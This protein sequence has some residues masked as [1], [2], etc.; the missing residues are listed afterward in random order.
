[1]VPTLPGALIALP[2]SATTSFGRASGIGSNT[3]FDRITGFV[4][5]NR[6]KNCLEA[7]L[8]ARL[9][10][11]KSCRSCY[12]VEDLERTFTHRAGHDGFGGV[13]AVFGF[14]ED[15]GLRA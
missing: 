2:P 8:L 9:L 14:G 6:M 7:K 10:S 13:E 12:P 4:G 5:I 11:C 15:D 1:M 3:F